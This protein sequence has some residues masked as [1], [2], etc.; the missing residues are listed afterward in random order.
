VLLYIRLQIIDVGL[1]IFIMIGLI[2]TKVIWFFG[3]F[4]F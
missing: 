2:I 4:M 3:Q 1:V